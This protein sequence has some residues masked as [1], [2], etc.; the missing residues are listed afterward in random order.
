MIV[1]EAKTWISLFNLD[2][3][4]SKLGLKLA[5]CRICVDGF[6][7]YFTL[8]MSHTVSVTH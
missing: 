1:N 4:H 3:I 6:S 7:V 2:L 8:P 5:V